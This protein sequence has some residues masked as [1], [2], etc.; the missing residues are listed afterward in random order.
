MDILG[1]LELASMVE[2]AIAAVGP[3]VDPD[4]YPSEPAEM[5]PAEIAAVIDHTALK[6][7]TTGELIDRLCDEASEYDF[8]GV[9]VNPTWTKRCAERLSGSHV[10]ICTV[11]GFPLGATLPS[12]KAFEAAQA[13]ADGAT[14]VDMVINV[15]RLKDGDYEYV[16]VDIAGVVEAAHAGGAL[17]K[18]ILETCLL[19]T[20]EKIAG[21]ALGKA[22]GVDFVKTST[23]FSHAGATLADVALMRAA[24]GPDLGVKAA[25]G[26]RNV[27]DVQNMVAAG[28]TRIGASAGVEIMQSKSSS[29]SQSPESST[30]GPV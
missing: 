24:V 16:F 8:A 11:I 14:E 3:L 7:A 10:Q 6:P 25:G 28:A 12:V 2:A 15:G 19:T 30:T 21:C 23:G 13:V 29:L 5:E 27:S 20:D 17:V 4:Y 26:V 18:V 22:A 9:C 1:A